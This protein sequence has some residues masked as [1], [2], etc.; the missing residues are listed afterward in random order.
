MNGSMTISRKNQKITWSK[1][2]WGQ[3]NPKSEGDQESSPKREIHSIA[4]V[5]QKTRKSSDKQS[6][7]TLKGTWKGKTNKAQC[8]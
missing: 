1:W 2:K 5:S 6:N 7:F 8:E 3:N 4:G